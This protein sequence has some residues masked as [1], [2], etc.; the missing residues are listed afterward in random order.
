[1]TETDEPELIGVIE[2]DDPEPDIEI[3]P[4]DADGDTDTDQDT[5][6]MD[7][8]G[9]HFQADPDDDKGLEAGV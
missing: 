4:V 7:L 5:G 3:T 6:D 9:Q 1:M 8:T 2:G